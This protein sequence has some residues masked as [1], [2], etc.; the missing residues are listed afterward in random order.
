[1]SS[2][3]ADDDIRSRGVELMSSAAG[4]PG[5]AGQGQPT[6]A[7]RLG[8]TGWGAPTG[9]NRLGRTGWGKGQPVPQ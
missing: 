4:R 7:S 9:A 3:R 5:P 8:Q 6:W 1:M 2:G